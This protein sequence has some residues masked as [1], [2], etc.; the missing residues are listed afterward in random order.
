MTSIAGQL[1]DFCIGL[2]TRSIPDSV[3]DH[4]A[5]A[6]LD[7]LGA[8]L[9][10]ASS[11]SGALTRRLEPLLGGAPEASL[12]GCA[13]RTSICL[14]ALHN[15]T[16]SSVH[17][18]DDVHLD[19]AIHPSVV[20]MPAVLAVA[21]TTRCGARELL[22]G[23]IAGY[24]VMARVGWMLGSSHY[25]QWHTTSTAGCFGAAAA[26]GFV[27]GLE[28]GSLSAA[29]GLAG[30]QSGGVWEGISREAVMVKHFHGGRAAVAGIL[31]AALARTGYPG[32]THVLE[33]E[34]GLVAAASR[35]TSADIQTAMASLGTDFMVQRNFFKR[36]PCGLGNYQGIDAVATLAQRAR[37]TAEEVEA[38]TVRLV[39]MSAW[40]VSNAAP[41]SIFE[42][43]F[44][45]PFAIA[46]LLTAGQLGFAEY[47]DRWLN[48][49]RIRDLMGRVTLISDDSLPE[50]MA[51]VEIHT[52]GGQKMEGEGIWRNLSLSEVENKFR[53][54]LGGLLGSVSTSRFVDL[55]YGLPHANSTT[56]FF[57][58][59]AGTSVLRT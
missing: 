44:S 7:W 11:E 8:A 12:V 59:L 19:T 14:A 39:S 23:I 51:V 25:Q 29:L 22:G 58:V 10:G 13:Q 26:A 6:L 24:E 41:T 28:S 5:A 57:E 32:A 35:S 9:V 18:L 15:G 48:D 54:V 50:N 43:K 2:R 37:I 55:V 30:A 52:R 27:W 45:L 53:D 36:Y 17:E 47:N 34:R 49:P 16:I 46:T 31:A 40:M 42:A 4:A 33:G 20:V 56:S 21:E 3:L 1:A 38:V